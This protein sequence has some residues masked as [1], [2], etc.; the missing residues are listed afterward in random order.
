MDLNGL[1]EFYTDIGS[2]VTQNGLRGIPIELYFRQLDKKMF[3]NNKLL[4]NYKI[5]EVD[6]SLGLYKIQKNRVGNTLIEFYILDTDTYLWNYNAAVNWLTFLTNFITY[7]SVL[8]FDK[9]TFASYNDSDEKQELDLH[10]LRTNPLPSKSE[11]GIYINMYNNVETFGVIDVNLNTL[12]IKELTTDCNSYIY[13]FKDLAVKNLIIN[14][15]KKAKYYYGIFQGVLADNVMI[16]NSDFYD[17]ELLAFMFHDS[18]IKNLSFKNC[19]FKDDYL[20]Y[21]LMLYDAE[22]KTFTGDFACNKDYVVTIM[23]NGAAKIDVVRIPFDDGM[24][25]ELRRE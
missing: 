8:Y 11:V 5:I 17:A 19:S 10:T 12:Q 18:V 15:I 9:L 7:D 13:L 16:A 20:S 14:K 25:F 3:I 22:L 4:G 23:N 6:N 1:L 2:F 24:D 21:E